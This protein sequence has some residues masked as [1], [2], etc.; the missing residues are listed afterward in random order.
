MDLNET[1]DTSVHVLA[2][3]VANEMVLLDKVQGVY[4]GLDPVGVHVWRLISEGRSLSEICDQLEA[5]YVVERS[6]LEQDV[7]SLVGEM[8]AHQLVSTSTTKNA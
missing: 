4:F 7:L 8:Q 2:C 6:Q 3:E 5:N 1:F